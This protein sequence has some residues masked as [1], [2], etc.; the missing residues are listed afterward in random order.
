MSKKL[1]MNTDWLTVCGGCHVAL[2]DLHEKLLDILGAVEILHCPLLTDVKDYPPA[3]IGLLSGA[4]RNQHDI[5]VAKKMRQACDLIVSYGTCAVYGG[6]PGA[7]LAHSPEEILDRVYISNRTTRSEHIPEKAVPPLE[8]KVLPL[9]EVIEVDLYLPGCPPHASFIFDALLTLTEKRPAKARGE[10]VCARC[11]RKM[12]K[13]DIDQIK[14]NHAGLPDE[15]NCFLCQGYLCMG[16]VTLDRCLA[17]CPNQ[18]VVCTGCAGPSKQVLLEPNRDIRT[19]I[20]NRMSR[21][22]AIPAA[23]IVDSIEQS[24]KS[25]YAYA[26]A[27]KM[28]GQKPTFLINRWIAEVENEHGHTD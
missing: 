18:G 3:D 25:H 23:E 20:A 27:S 11:E 12:E 14:P 7:A 22:T 17:P 19:E 5:K 13:T 10:T 9:D 21:L 6:I 26:M 24:A 1:R 16:S 8:K 2:V 28:I 4:I 15:D